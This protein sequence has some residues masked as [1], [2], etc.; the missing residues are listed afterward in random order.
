M[1]T[2]SPSPNPIDIQEDPDQVQDQNVPLTPEEDIAQQVEFLSKLSNSHLASSVA[3]DNID[4]TELIDQFTP[5]Q[6]QR[7]CELI[8]ERMLR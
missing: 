5:D 1:T 3:Q 4:I 7:L 6:R 2:P 8:A